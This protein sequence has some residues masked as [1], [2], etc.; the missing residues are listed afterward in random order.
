M[1]RILRRL[2]I[3][4]DLRDAARVLGA[5]AERLGF[6]SRLLQH[7]LD[8]DYVIQHWHPDI[9]ALQIPMPDYQDVEVLQYLKRSDFPARLVLVADAKEIERAV[10]KA[11][12]IGLTVAFVLT[13]SS[14]HDQIE[15]TLKQLCNLEHAA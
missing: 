12:S 15:S 5:I 10:K 6:A 7:T 3:I 1:A 8:L 11:Q 4:S 13:D 2:L 14:P 9:V